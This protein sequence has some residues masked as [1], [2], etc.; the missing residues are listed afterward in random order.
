MTGIFSLAGCNENK[1]QTERIKELKAKCDNLVEENRTLQEEAEDAGELRK[2]LNKLNRELGRLQEKADGYD[3][4]ARECEALKAKQAT[5]ST[6]PAPPAASAEAPATTTAT[7]PPAVVGLLD[8]EGKVSTTVSDAVVLIEGDQGVGSGFLARDG[9]TVYLFTAAHVLSGNSKLTVKNTAGRKF[10]KFGQM[11]LA[12][13]A[14]LARIKLDEEFDQPLE[15]S[16]ADEQVAISTEIAA[17]GNGGGAGVVS[18]ERGTVLGSSG[19]LVEIDAGVIQGNSGGPV[20]TVSAAKVVGVVTHLTA[21]R[22]DQWSEGTRQ[23]TV[24]RFACRLNVAREWRPVPIAAFLADGRSVRAFDEATLLGFAIATL[25]P[26]T[27][28]LR[29]NGM[30]YG[31]FTPLQIIDRNR[32]NPVVIDLIRFNTDLA[33]GKLKLGQADRKKWVLSLLDGMRS[34]LF[35]SKKSLQPERLNPYHRTL[36]EESVKARDKCI[37][38]LVAAVNSKK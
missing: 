22:N 4:L 13:G 35:N 36:A 1:Q 29:Y 25:E 21:A 24:R 18:V 10:A 15:V 11:E 17:L 9:G 27:D 5:S 34:Q 2:E 3:Q 31:S 37:T 26:G 14:D 6:Q 16:A 20:L 28:G 19:A 38:V 32:D 12:D 23:G 33:S 7:A 8:A 30:T